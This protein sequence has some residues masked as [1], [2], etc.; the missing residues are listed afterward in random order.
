MSQTIDSSK[1]INHQPMLFPTKET[2]DFF[3]ANFLWLHL[4]WL[5]IYEELNQFEH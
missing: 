1:Y 4:S 3:Q 2:F 5:M